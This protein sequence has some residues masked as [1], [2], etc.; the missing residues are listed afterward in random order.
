MSNNV[1]ETVPGKES[2]GALGSATT[3]VVRRLSAKLSRPDILY[4][5][6]VVTVC[7]EGSQDAILRITFSGGGSVDHIGPRGHAIEVIKQ[8]TWIGDS[9]DS[10]IVHLGLA[11]EMPERLTV[12]A[13]YEYPKD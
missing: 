5:S 4:G 6:L 11:G 2:L 10:A 3:M 13:E 12:I 9:A 1:F 7:E 8:M